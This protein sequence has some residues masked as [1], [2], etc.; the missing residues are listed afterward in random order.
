MDAQHFASPDASLRTRPLWFWNDTPTDAQLDEIMENCVNKCGYAGFGILPY[1]HCDL[2]YLKEDY[3]ACYRRTIENAKKLSIKMCL[4]DE[5][6]FPSGTAGGYMQK[7]Y[8][9]HCAK[10][11][12]RREYKPVNGHLDVQL[13]DEPLM[14]VVALAPD[15]SERMDLT[16]QVKEGRLS[17]QLSANY[18]RVLVFT[19]V[20]D[21]WD[22]VDYLS[23][24]AVEKFIEITHE[25]Y[26][27]EFGEY[28]GA[29][30]IID[31]T[32]YDE[33]QFYACQGRMWCTDYNEKFEKAFGYSPR[34][35]Y[36]D[37]WEDLDE[38]SL[39]ARSRLF[40]FR[41]QLYANGYPKVIQEWARRYGLSVTGHVDQEEVKNPTCITGDLM[42]SFKYQDMPGIDEVFAYNRAYKSY[43]I[44]SS[45]AYN[46]DKDLVMVETFGATGTKENPIPMAHLYKQTMEQFA[47]GV[48]YSVPH[49]VWL[50][51]YRE[52]I[53]P[54][55][56]SYQTPM[57]GDH[58]MEF[59]IFA[60]RL[61]Y[62]LRGGRHVADIAVYYPIETLNAGYYFERGDMY[63]G[64]VTPPEAD[65]QEIGDYIWAA[66]R[67]DF[68]FLHPEVLQ[69]KCCVDGALLRLENKKNH[70]AYQIIVLPGMRVMSYA[71]MVK[72][73][74]FYR[75]GGKIIA[76]TCLADTS[77][78]P[79][80]DSKLQ[81]LMKE[82]FGPNCYSQ[83]EIENRNDVSGQAF[84]IRN[85]DAC[86]M[87]QLL[88]QTGIV[89]DVTA[90][91][92]TYQDPEADK[93][94]FSYI[95]K[96]KENRELYY[97]I[98]TGDSAVSA[99]IELR[100]ELALELWH[101]ENGV[102]E[103]ATVAVQNGKTS[104][105]LVLPAAS[106]VFLVG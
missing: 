63:Q 71:S 69:Q 90:L 77:L 9:Q 60:S 87:A 12:D 20:L 78:E 93:G 16:D 8:P 70:E 34:L 50:N 4:Y 68:T 98:N 52:D 48:N 29:D 51:P 46:W 36:P 38:S 40:G 91:N 99:T 61:A 19:C 86:R 73:A 23:P 56:L 89:F 85:P 92:V 59:N 76:T 72:I 106:S 82:V 28:F 15:S 47:L 3:F 24:E 54:P 37:L 53:F 41:A 65:Y 49:A 7:Y 104:M 105:E 32:F 25:A 45:S 35:C 57:Y 31:S 103:P 95:H 102:T 97:F 22:R 100:G 13:P 14:A 44:V 5:W 58:L 55:E 39:S 79:G 66:A 1:F 33:P 21:G 74:E 6:G 11:L 83:N 96:Q 101:P 64:G 81:G 10:R 18:T 84:F 17:V 80:M 88:S 27:R 42:L 62:M 75:S 26:R 67:H 43:K 94:H 30:N 2:S